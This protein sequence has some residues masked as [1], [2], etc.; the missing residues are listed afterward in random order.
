MT[1]TEKIAT[2]TKKIITAVRASLL[3]GIAALFALFTIPCA[4]GAGVV[5]ADVPFEFQIGSK[6]LPA[7]EYEFCIDYE[8]RIVTVASS[9]KG[10][11]AKEFFFRR[12]AATPHSTA[13]DAHIVFDKVGATYTLSEL[14]QPREDGVRDGVLVHATKGEHEHYLLHVRLLKL[15]L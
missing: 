7:G 6:T 3:L 10:A 4:F 12:L 5:K 14:W 2:I 8:S 15:L 9:S 11:I 13:R 1:M